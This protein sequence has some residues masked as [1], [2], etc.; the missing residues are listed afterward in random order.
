MLAFRRSVLVPMLTSG[1]RWRWRRGLP[2]STCR[3]FPRSGG[4]GCGGRGATGP[5][6]RERVHQT[7]SSVSY[8]FL[9]VFFF[10]FSFS[11]PHI[12]PTRFSVVS[13]LSYLI[14]I[15]IDRTSSSAAAVVCFAFDCRLGAR[16]ARSPPADREKRNRIY[17]RDAGR[18]AVSAIRPGII[19]VECVRRITGFFF[20]YSFYACTIASKFIIFLTP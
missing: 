8:F 6:E 7:R 3:R 17:T 16:A 9:R 4:G 14:S 2:S 13:L 11:P 18:S 10:L 19:F 15:Y 5:R 20:F 1:W 12:H